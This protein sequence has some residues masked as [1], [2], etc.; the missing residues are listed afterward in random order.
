MKSPRRNSQRGATALVTIVILV[1]VVFA[2]IG[3]GLD[4][5][6]LYSIKGEVKSAANAAAL[7]AANQLIGTDVAGVTA[8]NAAM[9][10]YD[11]GTALNNRYYFHGLPIGQTSG[12]LISSVDGPVYYAAAADAIA[13][14]SATGAEVGPS[15]ARYARVSVTAQTKLLFWSFLPGVSDRTIQVIGTAVAGVSAPL[16]QACGIEP[17]ALA[18]MNPSD[19]VDF[20]FTR[21]I[22][23]SLYYACTGAAPPIL[24]GGGI[25]VPYVLLNRLD[26]NATV[27][28]D[29]ASQ[30]YRDLAGGLPGNTDSSVACFRIN[31][32]EISW[33]TAI[34]AACSTAPVAPVVTYA[35]CGLDARFENT[36]PGSC[37]LI[38][39]VDLLATAYQPDTDPT[40][41]DVYTD[42]GGNGRRIITIPIVDVLNPAGSMNVLGFRQF[43]VQPVPGS[44]NIAAGDTMGRFLAMYIGSVAPV[45]QGRFDGC[46]ISNGPGKVVL[47]Q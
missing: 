26:P 14:T 35:L 6:I 29:E 15:L 38:P 2:L 16:C 13:A 34:V 25:L 45:K 47:H 21:D 46:Q 10:T 7:A 28:A 23:Y 9:G 19:P 39:S 37:E 1:P 42:Y 30:A 36:V 8:M 43:L 33:A 41:T 20:G 40:N 31:N 24:P 12:T 44:V 22:T 3:F 27:F 32:P 11:S 18:A 17:Y 4:L 5:G